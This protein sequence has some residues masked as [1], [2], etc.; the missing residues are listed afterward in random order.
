MT[1]LA[2]P[3]DVQHDPLATR[4]DR[5]AAGAVA[6][7]AGLLFGWTRQIGRPSRHPGLYKILCASRSS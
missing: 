2:V 5:L 1:V 4:V 7:V 3:R 6:V